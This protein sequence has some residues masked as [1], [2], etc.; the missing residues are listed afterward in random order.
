MFDQSAQNF[1]CEN[2]ETLENKCSTR[3]FHKNNLKHKLMYQDKNKI[4]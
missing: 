4:F 1:K 2:P 3:Q